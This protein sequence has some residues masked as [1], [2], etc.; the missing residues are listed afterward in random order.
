MALR[1]QASPAGVYPAHWAPNGIAYYDKDRFPARYRG[2]LFIAF[3]GSWNRAPYVQA[4]YNVVY[5]PLDGDRATGQCE[6]FADGF[7]GGVRS[8]EGAVHRPSGVAVAP[9]GALYVSDDVRGRIYRI[10]YRGGP[11]SG[12]ESFTPCPSATASAGPVLETAAN[13]PEGTH[14]DVN[15]PVPAGATP[16]MVALGERIYRGQ[17]GTAACAG[18]H[19]ANGDGSPLGPPLTG[20]KWSW[21]DGRLG[22]DREDHRRRCSAAQELSE[23]HARKRRGA[24]DG[25]TGLRPCGLRLEPEPPGHHRFLEWAGFPPRGDR[26][27]RPEHRSGESDLHADRAIRIA[28]IRA[29]TIVSLKPGDS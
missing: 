2:G 15:V 10:V 7:A 25:G 4:G 13:P 21:S 29:R 3:H 23:P 1:D 6:I 28:S 27:P 17:V 18:C 5:Q 26:H 19:G 9:D 14:P 20:Q 24:T 12:G 16:E 22:G 8:P 11:G